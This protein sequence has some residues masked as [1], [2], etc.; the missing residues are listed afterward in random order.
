MSSYTVE[1][2]D[3]LVVTVMLADAEG[4]RIEIDVQIECSYATYEKNENHLYSK[5]V[6]YFRPPSDQQPSIVRIAYTVS[7]M[8]YDC[9]Q[10]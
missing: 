4:D 9:D 3:E 8:C 7:Q 6:F 2:G 10:K 5:V 1:A